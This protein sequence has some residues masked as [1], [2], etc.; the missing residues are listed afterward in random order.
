MFH[1]IEDAIA[2]LKQG[3][4][5]I[6]VDDENRENE[7]DFVGLAE[8]STPEM[9]N[10]MISKGKGL[11]C[12]PIT[13]SLAHRLQLHPMVAEN[14]DLHQTAFTVSIDHQTTTTGISAYERAK[15]IQS[16]IQPDARA[17]DFK[18]PGH[19]FPL[20]AKNEGVLKRAGHTEAAVDLAKLAG[21][22]PAGV[23][24][25][26]INED[27]T[28]ARVPQLKEI[29]EQYNLKMI[30]IQDLIQY[31][32]KREELIKKEVEIELPTGFGRFKAIGYTSLYDGKEHIALVKGEIKPEHPVLVRIHSECLTG[33]VFHSHRCDCGPQ[34]H[35][36]LS[37]IEKEGSGILLYLRQEG[38]GIGLIN[39]LKAYKLQE[40][41]YDT[42]EANEELGFQPDQREYAVAAQMLKDI[43]AKSIRLMTN[44]PRKMK[45]MQEYGLEILERV[46]IEIP[47]NKDNE[48]YLKTKKSK[49]GHLLH[50]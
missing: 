1:S 13:E 7:G 46:P 26:I 33:D 37:E 16:L 45:E 29:A 22:F 38:R 25:E 20:I 31:R 42:V 17:E 28:M 5:I 19:V 43:G 39:K 2:D 41:G 40:K 11:V 15:T 18:R 32:R 6:V 14:T 49:L 36:A 4:V 23:I 35:S 21:C 34:L 44:N 50:I 24:C 3:K 8:F 48:K 47:A 30:T 10:F 9:I 27:G 12:V